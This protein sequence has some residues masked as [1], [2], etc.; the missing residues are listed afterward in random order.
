MKFTDS[1]KSIQSIV[2]GI[3]ISN[4]RYLDKHIFL[5]SAIPYLPYAQT[6]FDLHVHMQVL[7]FDKHVCNCKKKKK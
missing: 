2:H 5:K 4:N 6:I 7:P 3:I 1:Y